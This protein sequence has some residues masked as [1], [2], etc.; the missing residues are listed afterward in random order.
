MDVIAWIGL[1]VSWLLVLLLVKFVFIVLRVL[2][3]TRRLAQM[4]RDAA[5]GLADNLSN[6]TVFTELELLAAQ[7]PEAVAGIPRGAAAARPNVSSVSPG[8]GGRRL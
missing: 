7:L 3:Q 8:L 6:D 5:E 2:K 1:A 4:S